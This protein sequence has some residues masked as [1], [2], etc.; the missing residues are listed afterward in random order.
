M[1]SAKDERLRRLQM[2]DLG[3]ARREY[4]STT[5]NKKVKKIRLEDIEATRLS[6]QPGT[7]A[8]RLAEKNQQQLTEWKNV[9]KK[10]GDTVDLEN[11]DD[12]QNGQSH[13]LQLSAALHGSGSHDNGRSLMAMDSHS[14]VSETLVSASNRGSRSR[15]RGGGIAGTRGRSD[16]RAISSR[17]VSDTANHASACKPGHHLHQTSS[18][19]KTS[20]GPALEINNCDSYGKGSEKQAQNKSQYRLGKN[21]GNDQRSRMPAVIKTRRPIRDGLQKILSPPE[22]FLAEA[23]KLLQSVPEATPTTTQ[24]DSN[25]HSAPTTVAPRETGMAQLS[26]SQN[27]LLPNIKAVASHDEPASRDILTKALH[28]NRMPELSTAQVT[29]RLI[30][31]DEM[32]QDAEFTTVI[33]KTIIKDQSASKSVPHGTSEDVLLDLSSAPPTKDSF[34]SDNNLITSPSLQ[35][36][37]GLEFVQSLTNTLESTP[38]NSFQRPECGDFSKSINFDQKSSAIAQA[39]EDEPCDNFQRDIELLC[40]LM[41]STSLSNKHRESLEEYKAELEAKL[42]S[43]QRTPTLVPAALEPA[44]QSTTE[45]GSDLSSPQTRDSPHLPDRLNVAAAPFVPSRGDTSTR[46]RASTVSFAVNLGHIYGDRL[47][48][49]QCEHVAKETHIFG[50]HLLPGRRQV[51]GST[52]IKFNIPKKKPVLPNLKMLGLEPPE[53]P[54]PDSPHP[55]RD[56]QQ[57]LLHTAPVNKAGQKPDVRKSPLPQSIHTPKENKSSVNRFGGQALDGLQAS[58]YAICEKRTTT[59]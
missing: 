24:N 3:T 35:E 10:I 25:L 47:L 38:S 43:F 32:Y 50:D 54:V 52:Q 55:L 9:F 2:E 17:D 7:E 57:T 31:S 4:I 58:I 29:T 19:R 42:Q 22:C 1:D 23:R 34:V 37:E 56:T 14:K 44:T 59:R 16:V 15:G 40:K 36:L 49:G 30:I 8:Q 20:L 13:R 11:L 27:A 12:L 41:A 51:S 53:G 6:N 39:N 28:E 33:S 18:P 45:G 21:K 26:T 46:A 5:D 48:P